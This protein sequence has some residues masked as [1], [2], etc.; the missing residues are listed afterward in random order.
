MSSNNSSRYICSRAELVNFKTK[1]KKK[2]KKKKKEEEEEEDNKNTC[3][4]FKPAGN[5]V[6]LV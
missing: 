4:I 3:F 5:T 2:K 6:G 1:K